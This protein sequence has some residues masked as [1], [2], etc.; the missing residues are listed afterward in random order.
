MHKQ[1]KT[2]TNWQKGNTD[3][4]NNSGAI[5]PLNWP[6][7]LWG[8]VCTYLVLVIMDTHTYTITHTCTCT[9]TYIHTQTTYTN[10]LAV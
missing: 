4:D 3:I 2:F 5:Y 10:N 6:Q 7:S 8:G 1:R 9:H